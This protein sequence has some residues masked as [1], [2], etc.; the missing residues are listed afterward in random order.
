MWIVVIGV[1]WAIGVLFLVAFIRGASIANRCYDHG[2][3]AAVL[4]VINAHSA[5]RNRAA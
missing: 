5:L 2:H 1:M 3:E 4:R